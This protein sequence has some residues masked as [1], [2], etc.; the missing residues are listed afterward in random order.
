MPNTT[1]VASFG[2]QGLWFLD[3]LEPGTAAYNLPRAFRISGPLDVGVLKRALQTIVSRHSSLRTVFESVNDE[4]CQVVL[5]DITVEIPLID[6]RNL[7]E[8]QRDAEALRLISEEGK[9]PFDLTKGPLLRSLLVQL[10]PSD[11]SSFWSYITSLLM[12][13]PSLFCFAS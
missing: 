5:S 13:G 4:C 10:G 1:F 12:A 3:Q 6:L 11:T 9:K 7:P 2:Q 8:Q